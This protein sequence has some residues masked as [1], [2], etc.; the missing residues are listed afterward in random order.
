M[1]ILLLGAMIGLLPAWIAHNKGRSFFGWWLFGTMFWIIAL[2]ISIL[3]RKDEEAISKRKN[4]KS[5]NTILKETIE[6][7]DT[8]R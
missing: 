3:I 4:R 5:Y 6:E 8:R 2:P 1:E 7:F